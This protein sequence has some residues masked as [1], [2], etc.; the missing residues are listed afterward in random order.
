MDHSLLTP[1]DDSFEQLDPQRQEAVVRASVEAFGRHAYKDASTDDIARAA[2]MSKGLLFFYCKNKKQLYLRTMDYLYDKVVELVV[3]DRFWEIDDF[4]ELMEYSATQK[5]K[6]INRFP[7]TLEFCLR[8][9][10]PEHR[11]VKDLLNN[12]TQ[13]HIDLMINRF[14]VNVNLSKFRDDED[15]RHV[16]NM[17]IWLADGWINQRRSTKEPVSMDDLMAEYLVWAEMLRTWAYKPE[18]LKEDH[19]EQPRH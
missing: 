16:L 4:F 1:L 9:Y 15:P 10:Y 13:K 7:W 6:V 3:D 12:W 17:V 11:D 8:A 18:Y 5:A 14:F 2:G 19:N